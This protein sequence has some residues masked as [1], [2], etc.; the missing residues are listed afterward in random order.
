MRHHLGS[1][2]CDPD[3]LAR[4]PVTDQPP[5]RAEIMHVASALLAAALGA[6]HRE[7]EAATVKHLHKV[8][9]GPFTKNSTT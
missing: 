6:T 1:V 5:I 3:H 8:V 9:G 2:F 7:M 4:K